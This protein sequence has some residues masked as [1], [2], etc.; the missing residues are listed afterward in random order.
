MTTLVLLFHSVTWAERAPCS[1]YLIRLF[2]RNE[3]LAFI[4]SFDYLG[5]RT[6]RASLHA[7][8]VF[9]VKAREVRGKYGYTTNKP[10]G[11]FAVYPLFGFCIPNPH[12]A[13]RM[14]VSLFI[15]SLSSVFPIRI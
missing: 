15:L 6:S 10:H 12:I 4:V 13:N 1:C 2:E 8:S 14:A 11:G 3:Y 5:G 7:Y 9:H